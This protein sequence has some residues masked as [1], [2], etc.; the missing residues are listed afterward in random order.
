MELTTI[1]ATL[2]F[3]AIV[4][5]TPV[6]LN[7]GRMPPTLQV[8]EK[9]FPGSG[10]PRLAGKLEKTFDISQLGHDILIGYRLNVLYGYGLT[11][12][13][14]PFLWAR[15]QVTNNALYTDSITIFI[16]DIAEGSRV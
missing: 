8:V 1:I 15:Q 10:I 3:T 7:N 11:L 14:L 13:S 4:A 6:P 16:Y 2:S 9:L 5:A 12:V